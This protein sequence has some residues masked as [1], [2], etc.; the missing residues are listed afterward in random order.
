MKKG[1]AVVDPNIQIHPNPGMQQYEV[2]IATHPLN[3]NIV[4]ATW[5]ANDTGAV[6]RARV[7][8]HYTSDG[9]V[10]WTGSD[11]LPTANPSHGIVDPAVGVDIDGN[12]FVA[13]LVVRF[14]G[15]NVMVSRS[16][17]SGL[18]WDSTT[19]AFTDD[20]LVDKLHMAVDINATSPY[21]NY[22]YTAYSDRNF[23]P[24][25]VK[26][27]RSTNGGQDFS[28]PVIISGTIVGNKI[29]PST[30]GVN[31][32]VS[33]DSVLYAT[34]SAYDLGGGSLLGFNKSTD[35]GVS[36]ETATSIRSINYEGS[37]KG[38]LYFN[39]P[40][41]AVDRGSGPRRGWIYIVYAEENPTLPDIFLIRSTDGG[42]SWSSPQKVNQDTSGKDHFMPWMS[43]DPITGALFVV[44]YDS[45]N[46]PA[47]DSAE[48][49]ISASLD[50]GETF[51]DILVSD[52]PF[53]PK[54]V[55]RPA[56]AV[57]YMGSYIGVSAL[58]GTVWPCWMD[59]RTGF[60]QAYTSKVTFLEIGTPKISVLPDTLDF[61]DVI[62]N[63]AETLTVNVRNL[64]YPDTLEVSNIASDT[65]VF[66]VDL[67]TFSV[68]GASSQPVKV[69]FNP[70]LPSAGGLVSATLTITS[71]DTSNPSLAVP[72][73]GCVQVI[74]GDLATPL[75][76]NRTPADVVT[77]INTV[78]KSKPLPV[79]VNPC[80]A[81]VNKSDG[82]PS[83]ADVVTLINNVFKSKPLPAGDTCG[84]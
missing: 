45:R 17:D 30:A 34:W 61:G 5:I 57:N 58:Q 35:G 8:W 53:L 52:V 20:L 80:S 79:G 60:H 74:V 12:L 7:G 46:F 54:G 43:V 14:P 75:N 69:T 56:G 51:E 33:P 40:S 65:S 23:N 25:P 39:Y 67:T 68:P 2:S 10:T 1:A 19:F 81:D 4:L 13:A 41:M 44:Y 11:T 29:P 16:T 9:G 38:L 15:S 42:S 27:S 21:Q 24:W 36:W 28:A 48:V 64:G 83:P 47:N 76:G 63:Q 49:Y 59:N 62:I 26:F 66:S 71:S 22:L 31:L 55:R 84:C 50:G 82:P 78:F 70:S 32:A 3:P 77:L 18:N 6:A 37:S 72:L 73:L